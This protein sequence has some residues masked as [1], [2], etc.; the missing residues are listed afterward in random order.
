MTMQKGTSTGYQLI[1]QQ[2]LYM[3][4]GNGTMYFFFNTLI[5]SFFIDL[6]RKHYIHSQE[7]LNILSFA[8]SKYFMWIA[9]YSMLCLVTKVFP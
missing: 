9:S 3:L 8:Y 4:E 7:V 2:K 5:W 1:S 6:H